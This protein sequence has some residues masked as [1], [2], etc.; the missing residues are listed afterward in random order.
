MYKYESILFAVLLE[1][2][3]QRRVKKNSKNFSKGFLQ[4]HLLIITVDIR[5]DLINASSLFQPRD[6]VRR[7]GVRG[8]RQRRVRHRRRLRLYGRR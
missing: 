6:S 8:Q 1:S 7:R 5:I 3:L 2:I 4:G